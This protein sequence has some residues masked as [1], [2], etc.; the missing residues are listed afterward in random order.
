MIKKSYL[1][2]PR[3]LSFY[4]KSPCIM[5]FLTLLK[6]KLLCLDKQK[7]AQYTSKSDPNKLD[8]EG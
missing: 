2:T 7:T 5:P 1:E 6:A 8:T 3:L 4:L